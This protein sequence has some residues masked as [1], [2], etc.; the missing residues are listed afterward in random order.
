MVDIPYMSNIGLTQSQIEKGFKT[1][2]F[3]LGLAIIPWMH[4]CALV[5]ELISKHD[6]DKKRTGT[7]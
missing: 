6:K 7:N 3:C 1:C 4:E 5:K 2:S